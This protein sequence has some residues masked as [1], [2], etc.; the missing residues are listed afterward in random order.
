MVC[1]E[2]VYSITNKPNGEYIF[3]YELSNGLLSLLKLNEC[4]ICLHILR[5]L[6]S[7][8][9]YFQKH[10]F[11]ISTCI[12]HANASL[13]TFLQQYVLVIYSF[14][15]EY[16]MVTSPK[17]N[18]VDST[19]FNPG[20]QLFDSLPPPFSDTQDKNMMYLTVQLMVV[21]KDHHILVEIKD[22]R[23]KGINAK[24]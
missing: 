18:S 20:S 13:L 3:V 10:F 22:L 12:N 14:V 8:H 21:M 7:K 23:S 2:A 5:S 17:K 11:I 16:N 24:T 15:V 19:Q 9:D 4:V 1:I 6:M